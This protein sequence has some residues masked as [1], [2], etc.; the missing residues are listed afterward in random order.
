MRSRSGSGVSTLAHATHLRL[1][2][3]I[4]EKMIR[5]VAS[6]DST[7]VLRPARAAAFGGPTTVRRLGFTAFLFAAGVFLFKPN[8]VVA[9]VI[10]VFGVVVFVVK[11][12]FLRKGFIKVTS[13]SVTTLG[14]L[15]TRSCARSS[16]TRLADVDVIPSQRRFF[17][18]PVAA[19][20]AAEL[21][22]V[23]DMRRLLLLDSKGA[24]LRNIDVTDYAD[25][26]VD[27]LKSTLGVPTESPGR[28]TQREVNERYPGA[29]WS[30][31]ARLS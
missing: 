23:L 20:V 18:S 13:E 27:Q 15:G 2:V 25:A 19:G 17:S 3:G 1:T 9:V 4:G 5:R 10:A 7:L 8:T 11:E 12:R 22:Q 26:D 16:I 6:A 14:Q 28:L 29:F 21:A 30:P 31:T 24:V